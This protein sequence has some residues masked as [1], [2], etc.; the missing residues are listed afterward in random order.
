MDERTEVQHLQHMADFM[1]RHI[2]AI[3]E[4][5]DL[6]YEAET[7][8]VTAKIWRL[9]AVEAAYADAFGEYSP[10]QHAIIKAAA[11]GGA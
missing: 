6:S 11:L 8:V 1:G 4:A 7:D 2:G 10:D 3:H 9:K 5:L